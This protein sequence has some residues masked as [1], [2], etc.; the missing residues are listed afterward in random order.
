MDPTSENHN[1]PLRHNT[2]KPDSNLSQSHPMIYHFE[3]IL[4]S[5]PVGPFQPKNIFSTVSETTHD[6]KKNTKEI[7]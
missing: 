5:K 2:F 1:H 6:V 7:L 4:L 3:L